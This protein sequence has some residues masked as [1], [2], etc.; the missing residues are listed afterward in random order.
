MVINHLC[1]V[2][3]ASMQP[4]PCNQQAIVV[5]TWTVSS[6]ATRVLTRQPL[7]FCWSLANMFSNQLVMSILFVIQAHSS[8][9]YSICQCTQKEQGTKRLTLGSQDIRRSSS[10][11]K[12]NAEHRRVRVVDDSTDTIN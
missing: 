7:L 5:A 8:S 11:P 1:D 12:P 9:C 6:R 2:I 3:S 10:I 4:T